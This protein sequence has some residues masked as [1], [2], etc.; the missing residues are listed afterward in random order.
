MMELPLDLSITLA[1]MRSFH[2]EL[3]HSG[4]SITKINCIRKHFSAVKGGRLAMA[5][6]GI[7]TL[8]LLVS[9]VP[10]DHLDALASGPALPDTSTVDQCR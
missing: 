4:A 5:A 10:P 2:R 8:S 7:A 3:V 9:D 6:A 1:E